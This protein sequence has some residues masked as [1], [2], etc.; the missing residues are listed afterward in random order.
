MGDVCPLTETAKK[1]RK[2]M[3]PRHT[4]RERRQQHLSGLLK[5]AHGNLVVT[6]TGQTR[7]V[8]EVPL[9]LQSL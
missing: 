6:G 4:S 2:E 3:D 1:G 9:L 7:S 8:S 5:G